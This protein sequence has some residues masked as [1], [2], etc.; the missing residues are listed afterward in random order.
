MIND[1]FSSY[2]VISERTFE[3]G[4]VILWKPVQSKLYLIVFR[5]NFL[6]SC[7]KWCLNRRSC[8]RSRSCTSCDFGS[9]GG[10]GCLHEKV[11][12]LP[13]L[14]AVCVFICR[15]DIQSIAYL[16]LTSSDTHSVSHV[17]S[18]S[19]TDVSQSVAYTH[20]Q[21]LTQSLMYSQSQSHWMSVSQ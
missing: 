8:W 17:F 7:S 13:S 20:P 11:H 3:V 4:R 5:Y 6:C 12:I 14:P 15:V 9:S 16:T 10:R 18:L 1:T 2:L 21:T 19:H